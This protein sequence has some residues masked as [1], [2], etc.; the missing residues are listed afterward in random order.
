MLSVQLRTSC[1]PANLEAN[2][3][4]GL[5]VWPT[6][7]Q[8]FRK[9]G[10]KNMDIFNRIVSHG[11]VWNPPPQKIRGF[12]GH[13]A[14]LESA[15]F[16]WPYKRPPPWCSHANQRQDHHL[17][18]NPV[19]AN[20]PPEV[21]AMGDFHEVKATSSWWFQPNPSGKICAS[22]NWES[23]DLQVGGENKNMFLKPP[24]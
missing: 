10:K 4:H 6:K 22:Q 2:R 5:H 20:H 9:F 18:A 13:M 21:K 7:N 24:N 19:V 15:L 3:G 1:Q 12:P 16:G 14:M 17:G 11:H 23:F 8:I